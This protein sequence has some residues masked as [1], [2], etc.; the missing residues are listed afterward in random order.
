MWVNL[1]QITKAQRGFRV[2]EGVI[3]R[4][5]G[6]GFRFGFMCSRFMVR[7]SDSGLM[8]GQHTR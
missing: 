4:V 6:S 7:V 1:A 2:S 8:W 3:L 5:S